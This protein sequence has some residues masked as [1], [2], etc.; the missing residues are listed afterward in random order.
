MA[1][2]TKHDTVLRVGFNNDSKDHDEFERHFDM[3]VSGDASL[4]KVID[5]FKFI[6]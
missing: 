1:C 5:L 3:V 2:D 4:C 6:L